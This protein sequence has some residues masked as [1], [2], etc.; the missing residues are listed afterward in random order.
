[1]S[2]YNRSVKLAIKLI[3]TFK[4]P[5]SKLIY[6][7]FQSVLDEIGGTSGM[8]VTVFEAD[9]AII[10]LNGSERLSAMKV[11]SVVRNK[12]YILH[13]SGTPKANGRA[14]FDGKEYSINAVINVA[15]ASAVWEILLSEG[16]LKGATA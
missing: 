7:E 6:Q 8:F 12:A 13:S 14:L 15:E 4:N 3:D 11:S 5:K 10:P 1:M 16:V 2:I 9:V